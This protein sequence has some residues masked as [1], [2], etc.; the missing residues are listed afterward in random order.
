MAMN[1][2]SSSYPDEAPST[3]PVPPAPNQLANQDGAEALA[4]PGLVARYALFRDTLHPKADVVYHPCGGN[5]VSPSAAFP[6]SRVIYVDIDQRSIDALKRSGYEAHT[7]SALEFDPGKVDVLIMLNPQIPSNIP[8][9]HVAENGYVLSN[10][11]HGTA[12]SLHQDAQYQLQAIIRTL[13]NGELIFDTENTEDYWKEIDSEEEF[14]NAPFTFGAVNYSTAAKIVEVVTGKRENI[15]AE[16]KRIIEMARED[17]IQR[18]AQ[19]LTEQPELAGLL[20]DPSK[21]DV[22]TYS[23]GGRQFA[24]ATMLPRKKGTVDDI[25]VFQKGK[26]VEDEGHEI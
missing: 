20:G 11:Y 7:A 12:S 10:D 6:D 17:A 18:N 4:R 13:P 8:S 24:I 25:F 9:S 26:S 19:T 2:P 21:D 14:R 1:S 22:L 3:S 16:Y 23:H 5:D 15:L